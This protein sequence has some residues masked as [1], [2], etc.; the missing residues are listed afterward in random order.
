MQLLTFA[1]FRFKDV[2]VDKIKQR[3]NTSKFM[4]GFSIWLIM[5]LSKFVFLEVIDV[6]FGSNVRISGF[7]GLLFMIIVMTLLQKIIE[8]GYN[9]LA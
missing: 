8:L 3:P 7:I 9:R 2:V 6:V 5:F 4:V 1:T